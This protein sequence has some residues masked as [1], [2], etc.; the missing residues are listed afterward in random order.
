ML[1]DGLTVWGRK[2][3]RVSYRRKIKSAGEADNMDVY[4][5]RDRVEV[6]RKVLGIGRHH[7][8][9]PPQRVMNMVTFGRCAERGMTSK[10]P[11][12]REDMVFI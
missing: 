4:F 1:S 11:G 6:T 8:K 2:L 9:T 3:G 7:I 5:N 12:A 10:R